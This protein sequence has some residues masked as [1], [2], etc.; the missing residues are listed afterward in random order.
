MNIFLPV[1][2]V[3]KWK[4]TVKSFLC[5][6]S[7][8]R[9][10]IDHNGQWLSD[11]FFIISLPHPDKISSIYLRPH[12]LGSKF[13]VVHSYHELVGIYIPLSS[14][15]AASWPIL[16]L[17]TWSVCMHKGPRD[18]FYAFAVAL[19]SMGMS[20]HVW[21][22]ISLRAFQSR[23]SSALPCLVFIPAMESPQATWKYKPIT[24]TLRNLLLQGLCSQIK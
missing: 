15:T 24:G 18:S 20:P 10:C 17:S 4:T 21:E 19:L 7:R 12:C 8:F 2:E 14:V 23:T 11:Y 13:W 6:H 16:L 9:T 3:I 5:D 1:S 22:S